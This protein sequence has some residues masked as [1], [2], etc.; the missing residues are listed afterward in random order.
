MAGPTWVRLD[1]GYFTNPK[2]LRAGT[3]AALLHLAAICYLGAH[4]LNSGVLS[5]EAVDLLVSTV[6]LRKRDAVVA[7][8]VAV[9]LW[10]E[11]PDGWQVHHY[12][13]MNGDSSEA[14]SARRRQREKRERDKAG[15]A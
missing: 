15:K 12:D 9:G 1:T 11:Q 14:A 6:R 4:Q 3:D 13:L 8:L 2:V 10:H 7:Q 5:V